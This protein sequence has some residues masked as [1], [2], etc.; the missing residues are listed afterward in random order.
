MHILEFYCL[1]QYGIFISF[2]LGFVGLLSFSNALHEEN[3]QAFCIIYCT[4]VCCIQC[5]SLAN[6]DFGPPTMPWRGLGNKT[7]VL[8]STVGQGCHDGIS[9]KC[10]TAKNCP[11]SPV[12]RKG[13]L[14]FWVAQCHS[15]L[16]VDELFI[17]R[18][19]PAADPDLH[20][21][22]MGWRAQKGSSVAQ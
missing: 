19:Q 2:F 3:L 4:L 11:K 20:S 15:K 7:V 5:A 9:L 10:D 13:A 22:V 6:F 17:L 21:A 12:L 18:E 1:E 14:R 16:A 8:V